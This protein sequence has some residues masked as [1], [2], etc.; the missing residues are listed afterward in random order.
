MRIL[1][2]SILICISLFPCSLQICNAL[3]IANFIWCA[4]HYLHFW[5][6]APEIGQ[7]CKLENWDLNLI[8][9][10]QEI[11]INLQYFIIPESK[12]EKLISIF[13]G[14]R[15]KPRIVQV[16]GK[17]WNSIAHLYQAGI[18]PCR[19]HD[20]LIAYDEDDES[21]SSCFVFASLLFTSQVFTI[22]LFKIQLELGCVSLVRIRI[23]S[24][25]FIKKTSM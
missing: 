5:M 17:F 16:L 13:K 7:S 1:Q 6:N 10:S 21:L 14:T 19:P 3:C 12:S 2:I 22:R 20:S 23:H 9:K 18:S 11:D 24:D 15:G 8:Q 25:F 4:F